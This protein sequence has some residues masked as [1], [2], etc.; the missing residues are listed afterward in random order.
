MPAQAESWK[1]VRQKHIPRGEARRRTS[2]FSKSRKR[3]AGFTVHAT[4]ARLGDDSNCRPP[5][6][7]N[8]FSSATVAHEDDDADCERAS[9]TIRFY[10][11]CRGRGSEIGEAHADSHA[12]PARAER[13][14]AH[15]PR[16][17]DLP[18]LRNRARVWRRLQRAHGRHQPRQGRSR[19][20][21]FHP[22]G[23]EMADRRLGRRK[24]R[25]K[26]SRQDTGETT[27]GR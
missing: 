27:G 3:Y 20:R 23:R 15:R 18:Q 22:R 8:V 26:T 14:S 11:R 5:W 10:S 9:R 6:F 16:E 12:L 21:R 17:G 4:S 24:P 19:I 7:S 13:L 1:D 2:F 25:S